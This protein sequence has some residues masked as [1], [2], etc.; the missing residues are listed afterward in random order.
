MKRTVT[1][2]TVL[3]C[4]CFGAAHAQQKTQPSTYLF[5]H[6]PSEIAVTEAQLAQLFASVPGE[7]TLLEVPGAIRLQG[8]VVNKYNRYKLLETVVLK[9]PQYDDILLAVSRRKD[10]AKGTVYIGHLY[11]NR[12]ADGYTIRATGSGYLMKK[13][14]T[15]AIIQPCHQ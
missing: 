4:C 1:L 3:F 11:S 9:L 7:A 2:L 6:L 14:S 12:H 5:T 8:T 15:D 10:A 13:I